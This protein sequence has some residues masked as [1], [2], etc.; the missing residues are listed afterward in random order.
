MC[1][2]GCDY[3]EYQHK[4]RQTLIENKFVSRALTP[5]SID[6][7][8]LAV[9]VVRRIYFYTFQVIVFVIESVLKHLEV[10]C[11]SVLGKTNR[12]PEGP[13]DLKCTLL[14]DPHPLPSN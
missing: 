6:D 8:T 14:S 11:I 1:L 3:P 4:H 9:T 10:C 13:S 2:A 5:R 12:W 7:N